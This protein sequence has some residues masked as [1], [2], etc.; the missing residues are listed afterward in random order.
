MTDDTEVDKEDWEKVEYDLSAS[1]LKTHASCP[2]KYE[3]KYIQGLQP[4]KAASGYGELG[5]WV[6]LTI[7]NVL[8]DYK[9]KVGQNALH[10]KLKQE[11]FRLGDTDEIDTG[12]IDDD[13]KG[14]A[15]DNLEVAARYITAQ[16]PRIRALE[17]P[18]NFHIDNPNIDRTVY[19]KMDVVTKNGEIWDWK[20]GRV[21]PEFTPRDELIQGCVYMAGY[22][23]EYGE[24]PEA[25][26]FAYIHPK[27]RE[28]TD[29]DDD[30]PCERQ[31]DPTEESW[32]DMVQYARRLVQDEA[33]GEYEAK[34]ESG[35]C[36]FCDYEL[37]CPASQVGAGGIN[38]IVAQEGGSAMWDAI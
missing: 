18:V 31:V 3:L 1:R 6:H 24:L 37:Y 38:Q 15:L 2:K 20:T 27:A 32:Q 11:F 36:Y 9:G 26:K 10:A 33:T 7:E 23:N 29:S 4:T 28:K 21:H 13:Q 8:Q 30:G 17:K 25:I 19:G 35:K 14:N 22:H 12:V 34:P 16:K 5:S